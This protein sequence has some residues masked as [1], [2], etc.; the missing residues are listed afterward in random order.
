MGTPPQQVRVLPSTSGDHDALWVVLTEGC[1]P[2]DPSTCSQTRTVFNPNKSSTWHEIGLF[3]LGLLEESYLGYNQSLDNAE[4]ANETFT[5]GA[6]NGLPTINNSV[7]QGFA[8]KDFYMGALGL[9]PR[10]INYTGF[11][12]PQPSVL[13]ALRDQSSIPSLSW[14]YTAGTQS[15]NPPV[16]GSLTLGGYDN[17]RLA[18]NNVTISFGADSS[19]DLLL[20]VQG[21]SSGNNQLLSA[22]IYAFIDS[23]VTELWLPQDACEAFERAFGLAW[24][25]TAELYLVN[26]SLHDALLAQNSNITFQLGPSTTSSDGSV[27]IEIPYSAFDL[28]VSPPYVPSASRYF[29]LK[30][31]Q[32][33]TQYTLGRT[34][35]QYAYIITDYER[36]Q[37]SV[38]QALFPPTSVSQ[39]LTAIYP[40][41]SGSNGTGNPAAS[42]ARLSTGAIIGISV[43]GGN[44]LIA[45]VALAFFMYR[46]R[47]KK[48]KSKELPPDSLTRPTDPKFEKPELDTTGHTRFE[49]NARES[50]IKPELEDTA[51]PNA[52]FSRV[53]EVESKDPRSFARNEL[54]GSSGNVAVHELPAEDLVLPELASPPEYSSR[55]SVS[56]SQRDSRQSTSSRPIMNQLSSS[57]TSRSSSTVFQSA[58]MHQTPSTRSPRPSQAPQAPSVPLTSSSHGPLQSP[59]VARQTPIVSPFSEDPCSFTTFPSPSP[60]TARSLPGRGPSSVPRTRPG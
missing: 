29:P 12:N 15:T 16:F 54:P 44:L 18:P 51:S 46:R 40:P 57:G 3:Q 14:S 55:G 11:S 19:R 49:L 42:E 20:G 41:K 37:F 22:G 21:I 45:A 60:I 47:M 31:A 43:A 26:D 48:A 38:H 25:D 52:K 10:A 28:S 39:N 32:N 5:L 8:T 23:L 2:Q 50:I 58:V 13:Q 34:F 27:Q 56:T 1:T 30:R 4:F 9:A 7:V 36:S 6:D 17:S 35:L 33:S 59:S 53:Y 24:N